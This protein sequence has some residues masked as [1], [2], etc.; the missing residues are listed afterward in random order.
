MKK[1]DV[2]SLLGLSVGSLLAAILAGV[3][4]LTAVYALPTRR[5]R[6]NVSIS[7]PYILAEG[8]RYQW[9]PYHNGTELDGF[10]DAI[11]L[12]NAIFAGTGDPLRDALTNP[13]MEFTPGD[14]VPVDSLSQYAQ[15]GEDGRVVTYA[16]YWH[17][18][19]LFLKPLLLFFTPSDLRL[20]NM[21]IQLLLAALVLGLCYRRKGFRLALP[22]GAALL[23]LNPVSTALCFQYTDVY[24][25]TLVSCAGML[26][27]RTDRKKYGCLLYLWLGIG[28][29]FLDFLTYPVAALGMLLVTEM[30]LCADSLWKKIGRMSLNSTAWAVGYG[31]MWA[32]K[33]VV[34]SLLTDQNV[35]LDALQNVAGRTSSTSGEEAVEFF[36][37]LWQN[38]QNYV[39]PA[40]ELLALLLVVGVLYLLIVKKYKLC[41]SG[42]TLVPLALCALYPV[43]WYFCV[44]NHSMIHA[45]MT[46]RDLAVT[47]M[48]LGCMVGV[49]LRKG[50]RL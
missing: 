46:H 17:G 12:S 13:R 28:I 2:F 8:D 14:M 5:M 26:A 4:L 31:G 11:M 10:T 15:G 34:A 7:L 49:S 42:T 33:W 40:V 18:Y 3:V 47:V 43:A 32:G 37:V 19:L 50:A 23:C 24:L 30:M 21:T 36:M 41:L 38:L 44:K 45:Y 29:G 20:L 22:M 48:A 9:A 25:L 6:H 16:R 27:F 35:I 1:K 39:N